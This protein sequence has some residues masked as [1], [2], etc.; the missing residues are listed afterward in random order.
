MAFGPFNRAKASSLSAV[1]PSSAPPTIRRVGVRMRSSASPARSGRPP[2]ETT[3]PTR[4]SRFE[5]ATRAA[6][7]PVL[8]PNNPR[9]CP[10]TGEWRL[11]Q[12]TA[13][14]SR[15][16]NKGM[17]KTF[18]RSASSSEVRRSKSSVAKPWALSPLATA[19]LRGLRRLEP[20]PCAKVTTACAPW[21][22]RNVPASPMG[23]TLT[24][25]VSS[26]FKA[27]PSRVP[28]NQ[29]KLNNGRERS[30]THV[31]AASSGRAW[32]SKER[33]RTIRPHWRTG[34]SA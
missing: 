30:L 10:R 9:A 5:A 21:G 1:T 2:R 19:M 14:A 24:S 26:P 3:A 18:L 23:G 13:S 8:A 12:W 28:F 7:A 33:L 27:S 4:S 15:A 31:N 32:R 11:S 34:A 17:S 22:I 6:A 25:R 20:L 16:A 29:A